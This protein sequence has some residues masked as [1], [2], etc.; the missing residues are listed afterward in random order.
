M[1]GTNTARVLMSDT[2]WNY[3]GEPDA[4]DAHFASAAMAAVDAVASSLPTMS[5]KSLFEV[6]K[7]AFDNGN[8]LFWLADPAEESLLVQFGCAGEVST[9][10][11]EPVLG[12][13]LSNSSW[14]KIDWWLDMYAD[15]SDAVPSSQGDVYN[16]TLTFANTATWDEI[17]AGDAYLLGLNEDKWGNDDI[18]NTL[19]LFA[20]AGGSISNIATNGRA[21]LTEGVYKGIQVYS[22]YIHP[23]IDNPVV[24]TFDVTVSPDASEPLK[25]RKTPTCQDS[26]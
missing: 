1:D 18:L 5:F 6:I 4:M 22:G 8:L 17:D 16:V 12:I 3:M 21:D 14:S 9:N 2:Y 10:P 23:Q 13:Y 19:R 26:R 24:I 20:P 11:T 25:V 7:A 15:V